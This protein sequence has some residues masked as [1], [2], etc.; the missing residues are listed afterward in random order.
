[1]EEVEIISVEVT[2]DNNA[3]VTVERNGERRDIIVAFTPEG[4]PDR[5][6]LDEQLEAW[7]AGSAVRDENAAKATFVVRRQWAVSNRVYP[8]N[9]SR[10]LDRARRMSGGAVRRV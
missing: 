8:V 1:M 3:R 2:E 4:V 9:V 7:L 5:R 6:Q 10:A